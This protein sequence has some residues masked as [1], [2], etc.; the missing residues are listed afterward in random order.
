MAFRIA[1][2][3]VQ[4]SS[5]TQ[6]I[7]DYL[8]ANSLPP[9]SFDEGGP[10]N[11]NLSTEIYAARRAVLNASAELQELLQGPS[12]LLRPVVRFYLAFSY[13]IPIYYLP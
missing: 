8:A 13:Y 1:K 6:K 2:L 12:E 10:A 9:P 5:N 7:D 3:T 4:I 11:L